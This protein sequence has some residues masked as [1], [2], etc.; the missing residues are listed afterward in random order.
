MRARTLTLYKQAFDLLREAGPA[1]LMSAELAAALYGG[2]NSCNTR[3]RVAK[4]IHTLRWQKHKILMVWDG[5]YADG[6]RYVLTAGN[7]K[8]RDFD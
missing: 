8:E 2:E 4:L 3:R 5:G 1:G 6:G 7:E